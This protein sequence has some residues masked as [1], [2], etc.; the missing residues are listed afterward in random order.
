MV[1]VVIED[2]N[3][4]VAIYISARLEVSWAH[5]G[6]K[7]ESRGVTGVGAHLGH[8]G[9]WRSRCMP[10]VSG[11]AAVTGGLAGVRQRFA[12]AEARNVVINAKR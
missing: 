8:V 3:V 4:H 7:G 2:G 10:A 9:G 12:E 5:D 6:A 1:A 11:V